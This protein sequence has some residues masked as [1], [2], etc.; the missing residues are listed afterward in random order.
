MTNFQIVSGQ[1]DVDRVR[2]QRERRHREARNKTHSI[3]KEEI[4]KV[5]AMIRGDDWQKKQELTRM[6]IR[7]ANFQHLSSKE[8]KKEYAKPA[9]S[10]HLSSQDVQVKEPFA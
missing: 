5:E 8:G 2:D 4:Q 7:P 10:Q 9:G 1:A 3:T 6:F